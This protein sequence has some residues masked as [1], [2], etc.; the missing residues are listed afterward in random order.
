MDIFLKLSENPAKMVTKLRPALLGGVI[1]LAV[2]G[3]LFLK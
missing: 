1:L 3:Y 2:V